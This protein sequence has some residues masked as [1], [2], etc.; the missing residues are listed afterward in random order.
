MSRNRSIIELVCCWLQKLVLHLLW[1]EFSWSFSFCA[2]FT[3]Y[4]VA[5]LTRGLH[6]TLVHMSGKHSTVCC[7]THPALLIKLFLFF[8]FNEWLITAFGY[9]AKT[10]NLLKM[11]HFCARL[12]APWLI[13]TSSKTSCVCNKRKPIQGGLSACSLFVF[14]ISRE[15]TA[16]Q[17]NPQLIS[18]PSQVKGSLLGLGRE[19]NLSTQ[20]R[21]LPM[22][23]QVLAPWS[24]CQGTLSTTGE[25]QSEKLFQI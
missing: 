18:E 23:N 16:A 21:A 14:I 5:W 10:D 4:S 19:E 22:V 9:R 8:F 3:I 17:G 13:I 24:A 7:S 6:L 12:G 15:Q 1:N 11:S 20:P 2:I 25:C